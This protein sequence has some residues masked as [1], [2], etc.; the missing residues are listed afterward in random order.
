MYFFKSIILLDMYQDYKILH[1]SSTDYDD[2]TNYTDKSVYKYY[3]KNPMVLNDDYDLYVNYYSVVKSLSGNGILY[4]S[5]STELRTVVDGGSLELQLVGAIQDTFI[6]EDVVVL[7]NDAIKTP[8]NARLKISITRNFP[9]TAD[10]TIRVLEV[11][12]TDSGFDY[13]ELV[14][15]DK[16]TFINGEFTYSSRY[17]AFLVTSIVNKD[18]LIRSNTNYGFSSSSLGTYL[19][20]DGGTL[21]TIQIFQPAGQTIQARINSVNNT[22]LNYNIGDI[23]SIP[24]AD[25]KNLATGEYGWIKLS[26]GNLIIDVKSTTYY[27]T[28]VYKKDIELS[29]IKFKQ[30]DYVNSNNSGY[31]N[32]ITLDLT[33]KPYNK[34]KNP[35]LTLIPQIINNI[36]LTSYNFTSIGE[37]FKVSFL[38]K[39]K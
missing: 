28:P 31:P 17:A 5:N 21:I 13:N 33:N 9:E 1:L 27:N 11:T 6:V 4:D 3:L 38:L 26:G 34:Y 20:N 25:V 16:D 29:N 22:R 10:C 12:A 2:R 32:L 15:I 39:K 35:V 23:I 19:Y 7:R 24:N 36:T 18:V 8:T 30:N 14:L 37:S